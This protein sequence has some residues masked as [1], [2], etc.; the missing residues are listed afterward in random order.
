MHDYS[1]PLGDAVKR[2]RGKL[3]LTQN[4]VADIADVDV[5]TVLNMRDFPVTIIWKVRVTALAI[6]KSCSPK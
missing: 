4:E 5:R 2:A 3:G 1:H 6:R